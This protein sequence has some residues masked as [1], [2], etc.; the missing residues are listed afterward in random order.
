M[1]HNLLNTPALLS[2]AA[3]LPPG[4]A[5]RIP[6]YGLKHRLQRPT[7]LPLCLNFLPMADKLIQRLGFSNT[8]T[9][10]QN[11]P[12]IFTPLTEL[13]YTTKFFV[14]DG[15]DRHFTD[16]KEADNDEFFC[17]DH[18]IQYNIKQSMKVVFLDW[19]VKLIVLVLLI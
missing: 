19:R 17:S 10:P 8:P 9:E 7:L 16:S 6:I 1:M 13:D 12:L 18:V 15:T 3:E 11:C 4:L 5:I 14:D 2:V